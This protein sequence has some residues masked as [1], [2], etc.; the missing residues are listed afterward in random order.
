MANSYNMHRGDHLLNS[1]L[2]EDFTHF[3]NFLPV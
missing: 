3:V 2:D 1:Y